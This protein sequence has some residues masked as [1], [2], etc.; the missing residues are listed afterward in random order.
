MRKLPRDV[1]CTSL[2]PFAKV[3]MQIEA[4]FY[5]SPYMCTYISICL[6]RVNTG[7]GNDVQICILPNMLQNDAL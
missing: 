5:V 3:F 6:P 1:F 2:G 4:M 7:K